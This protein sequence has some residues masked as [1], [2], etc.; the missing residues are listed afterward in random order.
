[1]TRTLALALTLFLAACGGQSG[2]TTLR[3]GLTSDDGTAAQAALAAAPADPGAPA[4]DLT[5]VKA[6]RVTVARVSVHV[7]G[8]APDGAAVP[9]VDDGAPGWVVLTDVPRE[10]DL[11]ALKQD[12]TAPL[13]SGTVPAGK[14]T[15]IRLALTTAG[16]VEGE[17]PAAPAPHDVIVGAVTELDDTV[18]D[19]LVP[20]SAFQPGIKIVHPWKALPLP[21]DGTVDARVNLRVKAS[22]RENTP[23]GCAYRLNPVIQVSAP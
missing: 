18:C 16:P 7:A 22:A 8:S 1:M 3:L 9:A 11:V 19:L 17:G 10:Y 4:N 20:H 5:N 23:S 6:I 15:Q 13:A 21:E 2:T 14:L 12:F